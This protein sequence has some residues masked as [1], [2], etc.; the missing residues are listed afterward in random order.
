MVI[1]RSFTKALRDLRNNVS[2]FLTTRKFYKTLHGTQS[3]LSNPAQDSPKIELP[4][5]HQNMP[6]TENEQ[7]NPILVAPLPKNVPNT[8]NEGPKHNPIFAPNIQ[9]VSVSTAAPV[10]NHAVNSRSVPVSSA[11][12]AYCTVTS[13]SLVT[14]APSQAGHSLPP[15]AP[16]HASQASNTSVTCQLSSQAS[17]EYRLPNIGPNQSQYQHPWYP[18]PPYSYLPHPVPSNMGCPFSPYLSPPVYGNIGWP[19]STCYTQAVPGNMSQSHVPPVLTTGTSS[20]SHFGTF[21]NP[22]QSTAYPDIYTGNPNLQSLGMTFNVGS[23]NSQPT[24][25]SHGTTTT[26]IYSS[27]ISTT[28]TSTSLHNPQTQQSAKPISN[29]VTGS[30]S[31]TNACNL[32]NADLSQSDPSAVPQPDRT[33]SMSSNPTC[34]GSATGFSPCVAPMGFG[35]TLPPIAIDVFSDD[36]AEYREF[37]IKIQSIL[38]MGQYPDEMKVIFLKSHL[39]GDAEASVASILPDDPG[40]Y[41]EIWRILDE[42]FGMA[43]LGFDHHLSLLLSIGSWSPCTTDDDLK[44]LYRHVSQ[45]YA[46][47]KHYGPDAVKLSEAAKVYILPLLTGHAAHKVTKL[48]EEGKKYNIVEILKI[49]RTIISHQKVLSCTKALKQESRKINKAGKK[50]I[51]VAKGINGHCC[52]ADSGSPTKGNLSKRGFSDCS[53]ESCLQGPSSGR[54]YNGEPFKYY[55]PNNPPSLEKFMCPFCETNDHAVSECQL[56]DSRDLYWEHILSKRWCS[57]CLKTGHQWRKC[58]KEKSCHLSC[59]R[60]DKHVAVLCDKYYKD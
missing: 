31:N 34:Y 54:Q 5:Q 51:L 15:V 42:D 2:N 47:L 4:H 28:S 41:E 8:V 16:G 39:T 6:N 29:S 57:N 23:P 44:Q 3:E 56:Y 36:I 59:G 25:L 27:G 45:N 14:T 43:D 38:S 58:F 37:K 60:V 11:S 1:T 52:K 9:S 35:L 18:C 50:S 7:T 10:Y 24:V 20:N 32:V 21:A 12:V 48:R 30:A 22:V 46:A 49:L 13:R 33:H 19:Y 53:T 40:A 26:T 17:N 55:T